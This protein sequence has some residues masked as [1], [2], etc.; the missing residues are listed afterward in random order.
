MQLRTIIM[1]R[2]TGTEL[3]LALLVIFGFH[4]VA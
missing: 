4:S 1:S 3:V 2:V